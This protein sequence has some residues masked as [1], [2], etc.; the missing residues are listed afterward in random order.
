M[1]TSNGIPEFFKE[2]T[3]GDLVFDVGAH[4]GAYTDRYL[5]LGAKV[6]CV[7]P[8]PWCIDQLHQKYAGNEN[9]IIAGVAVGSKPDRV[10]MHIC[11]SF[12]TL[13]TLYEPWTKAGRFAGAGWYQNERVMV[14]VLTLDDLIQRYGKPV[15]IKVDV[16]G[17][18]KE[19]I[20]GLHTP[21]DLLSFEFTY[22]FRSNAADC[23]KMLDALGYS[24]YDLSLGGDGN[25]L[26]NRLVSSQDIIQWLFSQ[27]QP[28]M[29]G[30]IYARH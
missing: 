18:E 14:N 1:L 6:V 9:V 2:F 25:F 21:V 22:E 27:P 7:E 19:V 24:G 30:D 15:F 12:R 23:L 5:A 28:D 29:W 20:E 11:H 4:T 17:Y 16:E 13:S 3:P 26:N 8:Q 10:Q